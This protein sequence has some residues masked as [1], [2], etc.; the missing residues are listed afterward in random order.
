VT[1]AHLLLPRGAFVAIARRIEIVD[2]MNLATRI[3]RIA[4]H[5]VMH[6]A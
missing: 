5:C 4:L 6:D 2:E 1:G 3:A